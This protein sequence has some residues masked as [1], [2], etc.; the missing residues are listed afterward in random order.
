MMKP[1]GISEVM[2]IPELSKTEIGHLLREMRS[3]VPTSKTDT[4]GVSRL[5]RLALAGNA[6]TGSL[7][8]F[9]LIEVVESLGLP[10][11]HADH[12]SASEII[13]ELLA[14]LPKE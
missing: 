8:P 2:V 7:P 14:G 6:A 5:L 3:A 11:L 10:P 1:S 9:R 4:A 12:A 13:E